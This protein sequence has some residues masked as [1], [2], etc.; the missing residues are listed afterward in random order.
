MD[1]TITEPTV[2]ER[3][4]QP[5]VA[6]HATVTMATI[7][8]VALQELARISAWMD[9]HADAV[10]GDPLIR[11]TVIDMAG[12]LDIEIGV[13]VVAGHEPD[14][15]FRAGVLPAGRYLTTTHVGPYDRLEQAT[16]LFVDHAA[17]TGVRWDMV[18]G[19]RGDE[20][21]CRLEIYPSDPRTQPD[22]MT[23]VT[24]LVFRLA[25]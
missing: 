15:E 24:Y 23:W 25:D 3:P 4:A 16:G 11:Y 13:P 12:E 8:E 17:R 22:P 9:S 2:V 18:P 1:V 6:L 21:G 10:A 7:D 5:Y 14:G 20:W 19:P